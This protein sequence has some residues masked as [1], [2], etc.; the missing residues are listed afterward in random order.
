MRRRKRRD[1]WL[2]ALLTRNTNCRRDL[3]QSTLYLIVRRH[4]VVGQAIAKVDAVASL[5]HVSLF[6]D[7]TLKDFNLEMT[8]QLLELGGVLIKWSGVGLLPWPTVK[9]FPQ[10]ELCGFFEVTPG[11]LPA[12]SSVRNTATNRPA[13]PA[14]LLLIFPAW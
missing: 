5:E 12:F 9:D 13:S 10:V 11:S 7:C 14:W 3:N 1:E 8:R 2:A 4:G 6:T